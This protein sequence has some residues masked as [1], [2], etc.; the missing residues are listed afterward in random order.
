MQPP[1]G[2]EAPKCQRAAQTW[3][4]VAAV[5]VMMICCFPVGAALGEENE[6]ETT[7]KHWAFQPCARPAVP[8][9]KHT[10]A[11]DAFVSASLKKENH[12]LAKQ[13]DRRTLIRRLSFDLRGLPP[14]PQEVADF[15]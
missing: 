9:G 4:S 1:P 7:G 3:L 2:N 8:P 14:S 5:T 11:I 13:A 6:K 15:L 12:T 10:N